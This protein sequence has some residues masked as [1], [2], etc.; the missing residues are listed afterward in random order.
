MKKIKCFLVVFLAIAM[1]LASVACSSK[2]SDSNKAGSDAKNETT[3]TTGSTAKTE[4]VKIEFWHQQQETSG[5]PALTTLVKE[6]NESNG[7]GIEVVEVT[8]GDYTQLMTALQA[9]L[10]GGNPPAIAAVNYANLNYINT[11]F[12]YVSPKDV[13]EKYFP[14]DKDY[15]GT[16]YED[17][18]LNLGVGINGDLVGLPYGLSVPVMY[19]NL[20]ILQEAGLDTNN[21]P[22][23]WQEI[24]KY[25]DTV[26]EKTDKH[27]L[28]IQMLSDTYS[29][30]PLFYAAG[31]DDMYVV[32]GNG[33]KATFNTPKVVEVWT[34]MQEM[35]KDGSAIYIT[36][37]E[38]LAAFAG[39]ELAMYL[40][41]CARLKGLMDSGI[42]LQ[43][44]Y[45]PKYE[46]SE[47]AV[48]LGGNMLTLWSKEEAKQKAAWEFA[49]FLIEPDNMGLFDTATGY[50]PPIKGVTAND[51]E[52]MNNP[53][54]ARL[55]DERSAARPWTSWPGKSG[56]QIDQVIV[57]M[58]DRICVDFQDVATV[59][60]ETEAEINRMLNE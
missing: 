11:N 14:E 40:T 2:G 29:I 17:A 48:C 10:A 37:D 52:M 13:I 6:F 50:V 20:D 31:I 19:Y 46:G 21:L 27:G 58:R 34:Y 23:T 4:P 42:N 54:I 26:V 1:V 47:L 30:I 24:R 28:Y 9:A 8:Y 39:G 41:S 7:K 44:Y 36:N 59:I 43:T 60:A 38:G 16:K 49:K 25:A 5:G 22:K 35:Y 15:L 51:W 12:P 56:A 53:L 57:S 18:V 45:H 33:Y 32:D 3:T 55:L